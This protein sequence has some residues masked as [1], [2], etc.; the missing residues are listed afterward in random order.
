MIVVDASGMPDF[1]SGARTRLR[2]WLAQ[3]PELDGAAV[4]RE[5]GRAIDGVQRP[6]LGLLIA[7]GSTLLHGIDLRGIEVEEVAPAGGPW[8]RSLARLR[9]GAAPSGL[10]ARARLWQSETVPPCGPRGVPALVTIHDARWAEPRTATNASLLRWLPRYLVARHWIPRQAREW[11]GVV[12][13]SPA[14][15]RRLAQVLGLP[16]SRVHCIGNATVATP[17]PLPRAAAL[18]L[19]ARHGVTSGGYF[20]ALG[21]LEPRKGLELALES[22][23]L[24]AAQRGT[25][26]R[27]GAPPLPELPPLLVVGGGDLAGWQA[28]AA[29]LQLHD[30]VRFVGRL[31][32]DEVATLL[33]HARALLFPSR[34]EGFG[35]PLYEAFALGC[36]VVARPLDC[37]ESLHCNAPIAAPIA[38]PSAALIRPEPT[39]AAW[40]AALAEL[41]SG[42]PPVVPRVP[43]EVGARFTWRDTAAALAELWQRTLAAPR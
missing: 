27:S 30:R 23:A 37:F 6:P 35:L 4:L 29:A 41:A 26:Q 2:G 21:H 32:D 14:A 9:G 5:G 1:A 7:R 34:Y 3:W 18:E 31:A 24:A 19:L 10:A 22:L 25:A 42:P 8:Q 28:R 12:T 40:A 11:A 15:A 38:T 20:V 36:P 39:A 17:N 33:Q 13:V 43:L 16:E